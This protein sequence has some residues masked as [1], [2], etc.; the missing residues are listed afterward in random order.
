M[1]SGLRWQM[2]QKAGRGDQGQVRGAA[3]QLSNRQT[4]GLRGECQKNVLVPRFFLLF[5]FLDVPYISRGCKRNFSFV[6]DGPCL[7]VEFF[8]YFSLFRCSLVRWR[9]SVSRTKY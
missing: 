5:P 7:T 9:V 1:L 8:S 3:V 6:L 2:L 4:Q